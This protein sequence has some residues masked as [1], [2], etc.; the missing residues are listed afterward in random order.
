MPWLI[1]E[2]EEASKVLKH[3][4][5]IKHQL[6]PYLY[7]QAITT[8]RTGVP[9][10]RAMFLEYAS[11][12]A[13]W[14]L[15]QQYMLGDSLLVAPVFNDEGIVTYYLPKGEWYGILDKKM[16]TGPGYVTETHDFFGL[17]VLLKPSGALVMGKGGEKVEYDWT[18]GFKLL[19]NVEEG[20]DVTVDL[21]HHEKLGET[22]LSLRIK[23][24]G[25]EASVDVVE[26]KANAVW[27]LVI[28][29]KKVKGADGGEV[30]SEGVVSVAAGASKIVVS[31]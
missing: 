16:R 5:S 24:T 23:A 29:N 13:V 31:L 3:F 28:V 27:D 19:V 14:Y 11:D 15:D 10:L 8:H 25:L 21:P 18:D 7:S 12:P 20:M 2:T 22:V 1:D 4:V 9:M 6:M 17:P 30:S 26:G